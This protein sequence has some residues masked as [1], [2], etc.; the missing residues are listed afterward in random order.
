MKVK[1]GAWQLKT[2]SEVGYYFWD[3]EI[4]MERL[5]DLKQD[6]FIKLYVVTCMFLFLEPLTSIFLTI[7]STPSEEWNGYYDSRYNSRSCKHQ[8]IQRKK[9]TCFRNHW[10]E[11]ENASRLIF[12]V[13]CCRAIWLLNVLML[14]LRFLSILNLKCYFFNDF[15]HHFFQGLFPV[16]SSHWTDGVVAC[17]FA[18]RNPAVLFAEF[19]IT[20]L[21]F[22][23]YLFRVA[24]MKL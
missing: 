23:F 20:N 11:V 9:G 10:V 1:H 19:L 3:C 13:T 7:L 12:F 17:T 22:S 4:N 24:A 15:K 8:G 6:V 16:L 5:I 18:F 2:L 14:V 21:W